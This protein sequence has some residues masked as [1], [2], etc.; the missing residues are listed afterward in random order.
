MPDDAATSWPALPDGE[1]LRAI[2]ERFAAEHLE[3]YGYH[4]E[5]ESVGIM[6]VRVRA[7]SPGPDVDL[8]SLAEAARATSRPTPRSTIAAAVYFG[9]VTGFLDTRITSR[10]AI[11]GRDVDG[12]AVLEEFDTTIL[13]PPGWRASVDELANTVLRPV[14]QSA[15]PAGGG[16]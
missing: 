3:A 11:A 8:R 16:L 9:P 4:R 13:V 1:A 2:E 5:G 10:G 15:G 7:T 6:N 14:S 12:P